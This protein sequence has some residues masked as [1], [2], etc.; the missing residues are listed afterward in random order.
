VGKVPALLVQISGQPGG[1]AAPLLPD[2]GA[3]QDPALREE[4]AGIQ[5][6]RLHCGEP[7]PVPG[8]AG[9]HGEHARPGRLPGRAGRP[10]GPPAAAHTRP[11]TGQP[12]AAH[13]QP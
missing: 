1:A 11:P 13:H 12:A 4:G 6:A 2:P 9:R 5:P 10:A 8:A 3:G 7:Y